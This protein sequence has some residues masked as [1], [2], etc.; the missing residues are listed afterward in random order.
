MVYSGKWHVSREESPEDRGWEDLSSGPKKGAMERARDAEVWKQ[1]RAELSADEL[2]AQGQIFRPGW[3][4][5]LV[6]GSVPARGPN[7][8]EG[9]GD[10]H[11][12]ERALKVL[13]QLAA[14]EEP[15]CLFI[16][17]NGPHDAFII[18]EPFAKMYDA[19]EGE[20]T[21]QIDSRFCGRCPPYGVVAS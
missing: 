12:V 1:A 20:H 18:P 10:Y 2:R 7:G 16:G 15:W 4:H 14:G 9:T 6:Y 11:T 5:R 13:P 8:Y 21:R 3:G 19:D 17:V